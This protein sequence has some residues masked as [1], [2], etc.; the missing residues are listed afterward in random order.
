MPLLSTVYVIL[1]NQEKPVNERVC[2]ILYLV[3]YIYKVLHMQTRFKEG[4][5]K[6]IKTTLIQFNVGKKYADNIS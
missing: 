3:L 2:P 1:K 5:K 6:T 4:G